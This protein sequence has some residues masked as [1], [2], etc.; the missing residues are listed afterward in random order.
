MPD[1]SNEDLVEYLKNFNTNQKVDI[2]K[3]ILDSEIIKKAFA[4][5]ESKLILSSV[6]ELVTS[7][8]LS[9]V[10]MC[11]DKEPETAAKAIYPKCMEINL[12]YKLLAQWGK[13]LQKEKKKE[14]KNG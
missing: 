5:P 13:Y 8:I 14:I 4:T 6:V 3:S 10:A 9:I 11:A 7:D 2:Y 12:A 1:I